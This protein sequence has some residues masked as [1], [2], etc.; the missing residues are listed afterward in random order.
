MTAKQRQTLLQEVR[1]PNKSPIRFLKR[2]QQNEEADKYLKEE[3]IKLKEE[4]AP[5]KP[6][7]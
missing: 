2:K 6:I 5:I 1:N 4:Y 3:L 7:K